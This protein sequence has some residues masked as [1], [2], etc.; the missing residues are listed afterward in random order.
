VFSFLPPE[1]YNG[2]IKNFS[3][4]YYFQE[5]YIFGFISLFSGKERKIRVKAYDTNKLWGISNYCLPVMQGTMSSWSLKLPVSSVSHVC[6]G[7][8]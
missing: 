8:F 7:L 1:D 2:V 3:S 5:K 4:K 6:N